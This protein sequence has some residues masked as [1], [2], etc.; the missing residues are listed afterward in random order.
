VSGRELLPRATRVLTTKASAER[1]DVE[2]VIGMD[3]WD[4]V[5]LP[6]GDGGEGAITVT[7][8]LA[9]HGPTGPE[10]TETIPAASTMPPSGPLWR[11]A[12]RCSS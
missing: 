9:Q 12:A 7:A 8:V 6:R 3:P 5:E 10:G 11:P 1:L 2:N 4:S